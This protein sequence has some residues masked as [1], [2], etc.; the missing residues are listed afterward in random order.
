MTWAK[1]LKRVLL[2]T[3]GPFALRARLQL[4]Q[5][6]PGDLVDIDVQ[7][8]GACGGAVKIIA[9][10]EDPVAIRKIPDHREDQGAV[11]QAYIGPRRTPRQYLRWLQPSRACREPGPSGQARERAVNSLRR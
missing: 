11:P 8:C 4:F 2:R 5:I 6:A 10:V 1:R 9:A 3:S 7:S